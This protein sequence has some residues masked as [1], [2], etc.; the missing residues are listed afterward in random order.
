MDVFDLYAKLTLDSK[1]YDEGLD[2]AK[3]KADGFTSILSGIGSSLGAVT[4]AVGTAVAGAATA[5][6][7]LVHQA[8]ESYAN[9]QQLIG[10]VETMFKDSAGIVED[11]AVEAYK[12]A[13]IS[14]NQYMEQITSFSAS[15]ISSL[16]GDTATAAELS[17]QAIIDMADNANKMGTDMAAI[18]N[19]YQGF[20]KQNYTMLDNLKLGYGGTKTEMERL[21]LEAEKLDSSFTA[22]KD[23]NG[24][25]AMSFADIVEAIHIVQE[26]M[27][28]TGTTSKEAG[29]TISGSW[30]MVKASWQDLVTSIAGGGVGLKEAI[31]NVVNSFETFLTNVIPSI[32]EALYGVGDL[33]QGIV[34]I[35]ADRLP[36]LL[37]QLTPMLLDTA[38]S[39]V[40]A[41]VSSLPELL[42]SI[43]TAVLDILPDLVDIVTNL[44]SV[45]MTDIIPML[46]NLAI[47]IIE[48]LVTGLSDNSKTLF[49]SFLYLIT[50]LVTVVTEN[51]PTILEAA[52]IIIS[53]IVEG[54]LENMDLITDSITQLILAIGETV[55][56]MVP[57]LLEIG[58]RL[59][60]AIAEG[61]LMVVPKFLEKVLNAF[62][63]F[64]GATD[65][66]MKKISKSMEGLKTD[67]ELGGQK[68][69]SDLEQLKSNYTSASK[70]ITT[71]TKNMT[72]VTDDTVND[73]SKKAKAIVSSAEAADKLATTALHS[74]E[75][76]FSIAV[77][78]VMEL[79]SKMSDV[80]ENV[81]GKLRELGKINARPIV[82]ASGVVSACNEIVNACE[83]AVRA[84]DK[85]GSASVGGGGFGGGHAAGGWMNPG[86]T[87][88]VGEL[89]PE[90]V[91]ATQRSYVHTADETEE[92]L[93]RGSKGSITI[94]INGDI[95]DDER[96]MRQ[97]MKSAVLGVI[98]EQVAYG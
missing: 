70:A 74:I 91:T 65:T 66:T 13:G 42:S 93:G 17:N 64:E 3:S 6:G 80:I 1:G 51:I 41:L 37:A 77:S 26:E 10:G 88:L 31:N 27:G 84:L 67:I 54:L 79:S 45:L 18:Q 44:L 16:G 63:V 23:A 2:N 72:Q 12:N 33:I 48:A 25:L 55:I 69:D 73:A 87:Y 29:E 60:L 97:K 39:L 34:P 38:V 36:D 24:N 14:A 96:S 94:N 58:G 8:V 86:T 57:E 21:V 32:E 9:Y 75:S 22:T 81:I 76:G 7:S 85:L 89:G 40:D 78:T 98:Q 15:M 35:I 71:T 4:A 95:Y 62:G 90:L 59:L 61:I 20:A 43:E 82:D 5:V 53:T 52:V 83:A 68:I 19:A 92:I 46:A 56:E 30:K 50:Y 47:N 49:D 11:Y 28:I